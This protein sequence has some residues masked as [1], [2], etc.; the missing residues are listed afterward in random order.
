MSSAQTLS[1]AGYQITRPISPKPRG[2]LPWLVAS[3][4]TLALIAAGCAKMQKNVAKV[5]REAITAEEFKNEMMTRYRTEEFASQRTL[6]ERKD[7]LK[8][9]IDREL[10]LQDAYRLGLD[11]DSTVVKAAEDTRK[12][13]AIQELYKVEI[14]DKVI[15]PSAVKDIYDKMGEEIRARHI[16]IKTPMDADS[17]KEQEAVEKVNSIYQ[18]LMN[19]A[20]FDSLARQVSEDPTSAQ[21]GGD[22]GYFGWGKMVDEFQNAAFALKVGEISQ[23]VKSSYGYHI[24]K[25]EDRRPSTTRKSFEE[26]KDGILMQLRQKYRDELNKAAEDYLNALKEEHLLKYN[27]ANIQKILDKVSD[28]S[29]PRNQSFFSD[30]SEEEK[31]WEAATM[32]GD[33]I[34][35]SDLDAEIAKTGVPPRWRDQ[36][37]I[38][39]MIER[40]VIPDFLAE[41]AKQKGLYNA[42]SV[43]DAYRTTQEGHLVMVVENKQI[44]DKIDLSDEKL[45]DYYQ[46]H[47]DE[48]KTDST[49]EVQEIYITMDKNKGKDEAFAKRIANRAKKGENFTKLVEKYTDRKSAEKRE[50]KIGPITSRQYGEL[51]KTAFGLKIGEISDPIRMGPNAFS[52]IKLLDKTSPRQKTFEE[53]KSEVER[54]LRGEAADSLRAAW[55]KDMERRYPV[56]I[57]ENALMAVLPPPTPVDVT[58]EETPG[59]KSK[60]GT[61][62]VPEKKEGEKR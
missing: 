49:V 21:N 8:P 17:V 30:F 43:K 34:R 12:Q 20:D 9:M 42:K 14:M 6:Q 5:G 57:Y 24:I 19:G 32:K 60:P 51:G 25:L 47:L 33:T 40:M 10:K 62:K 28:P 53:C 44:V 48:F 29:V 2:V 11:K 46:N 22:L 26:E 61:A 23:P 3:F 7:L 27:Y 13:A 55:S 35:V 4:V 1:G 54:K 18:L 38:I 16:L 31:Q 56:K 52:V 39:S 15:P 50:G 59:V 41:R 37:A 45:L 58:K 36:K